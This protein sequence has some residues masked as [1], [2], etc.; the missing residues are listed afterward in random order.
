MEQ[1]ITIKDVSANCI[2]NNWNSEDVEVLLKQVIPLYN[3]LNKNL[4]PTYAE[5]SNNKLSK[6][7]GVDKYSHSTSLKYQYNQL[8]SSNDVTY[9]I[10][11]NTQ[12]V[13]RI[14]YEID[15]SDNTIA[16]N[17]I[18]LYFTIFE[19]DG[20]FTNPVTEI[21]YIG[22]SKTVT[23]DDFGYYETVS[24]FQIL[25]DNTL[26]LPAT[27]EYKINN[28]FNDESKIYFHDGETDNDI[29][30]DT[31][32]TKTLPDGYKNINSMTIMGSTIL[33]GNDDIR[34][35]SFNIHN[36]YGY[37]TLEIGYSTQYTGA[38]D[39]INWQGY[40]DVDNGYVENNFTFNY[41]T[42]FSDN[43]TVF[44]YLDFI[45]TLSMGIAPTCTFENVID[46]N[47]VLRYY[48]DSMIVIEVPKWKIEYG[49]VIVNIT[50]GNEPV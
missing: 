49:D 31:I 18:E 7:I 25:D 32:V 44:L 20:N 10:Y 11:E 39:N 42:L 47:T 26:T 27:F 1:I 15:N 23:Y 45:E 28:V 4:H 14:Y 22:P 35:I 9:K 40:I 37:Q 41:N 2:E 38:N 8:V 5:I 29:Y 13:M 24:D 36:S 50:L 34:K 6:I 48:D 33:S 17:S 12:D 30:L 21:T 16:R 3:G 43:D 19:N 46:S